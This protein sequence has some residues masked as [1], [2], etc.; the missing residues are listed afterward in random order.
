MLS[1][2]LCEPYFTLI[3]NGIKKAEG[4]VKKGRFIN[5]KEG[6]TLQFNNDDKSYHVTVTYVEEYPSFYEMM[7]ARID[8][9]LPNIIDTNLSDEENWNNG[10][11]VY[12]QFFTDEQEQMGVL[13]IG[14]EVNK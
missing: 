5:I 6:D 12:K 14:V 9:L 10:V 4:R 2:K 1:L 13:C 11:A 3:Q 7:R 8:V